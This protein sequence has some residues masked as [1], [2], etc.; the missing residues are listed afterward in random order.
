MDKSK[1]ELKYFSI[2]L[3]LDRML[4]RLPPVVVDELNIEFQNLVVSKLKDLQK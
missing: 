2:Y 4:Q 3:N 1:T